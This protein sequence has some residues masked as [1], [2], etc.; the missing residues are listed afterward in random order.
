MAAVASKVFSF[1]I[2]NNRINIYYFV[3][4]QQ[5]HCCAC[6]ILPPSLNHREMCSGLFCDL[7][8]TNTVG[9]LATYLYY[10]THADRGL[11]IMCTCQPKLQTLFLEMSFI[12][13]C[14]WLR[15]RKKPS[16]QR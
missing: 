13:V 9:L 3:T 8:T 4:Y 11:S 10:N 15:S 1:Y 16:W 6:H 12:P 7:H 2:I 5:V 14:V